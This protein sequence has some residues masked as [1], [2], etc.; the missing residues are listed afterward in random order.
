MGNDP[1]TTNTWKK[2]EDFKPQKIDELVKKDKGGGYL[3]EV[4]VKYPKEDEN[5]NEEKWKSEWRKN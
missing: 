2:V 4:D 1:K 3:L 5:E